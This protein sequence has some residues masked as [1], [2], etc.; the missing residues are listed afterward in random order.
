MPPRRR[1]PPPKNDDVIIV[2]STMVDPTLE[3]TQPP[4]PLEQ[5]AR[6]ASIQPVTSTTLDPLTQEA[7]I[8]RSAESIYSELQDKYRLALASKFPNLTFSEANMLGYMMVNK[9]R[10]GIKYDP[11]VENYLAEVI[12]A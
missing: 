7:L 3:D 2:R 11:K 9:I 1:P 12:L 4:T 8:P 5:V 10:Y 6:L